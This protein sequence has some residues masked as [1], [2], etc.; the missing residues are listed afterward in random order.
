MQKSTN[1]TWGRATGL[2]ARN[3]TPTTLSCRRKP[4]STAEMDLAF[5][6]MTRGCD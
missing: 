6:E 1:L 2:Q 3:P 4:V 5:A